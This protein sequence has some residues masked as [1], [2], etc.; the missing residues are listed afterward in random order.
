LS[1]NSLGRKRGNSAGTAANR[2]PVSS[3]VRR[4]AGDARQR[5]EA[6]CGERGCIRRALRLFFGQVQRDYIDREDGHPNN[7]YHGDGN[8]DH[9]HAAFPM[10][11]Q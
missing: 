8:Q 2:A 6:C 1:G 11:R 4:I 9:R 10:V 7:G 5:N 3:R